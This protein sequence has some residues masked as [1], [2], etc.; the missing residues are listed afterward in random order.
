M[1]GAPGGRFP[2]GLRSPHPCQALCG[3]SCGLTT[4]EP[5]FIQTM[6]RDG[7]PVQ[8][9][10]KTASEPRSTSRDWGSVVI[11]GPT[12]VGGGRSRGCGGQGAGPFYLPL[13]SPTMLAPS[14]TGQASSCLGLAWELSRRT[15]LPQP[16]LPGAHCGSRQLQAQKKLLWPHFCLDL[17][18]PS[19]TPMLS[20]PL[21]FLLIPGS[22]TLAPGCGG[23]GL[24]PTPESLSAFKSTVHLLQASAGDLEP[25]SPCT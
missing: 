14:P 24:P 8:A 23:R 3:P 6:V 5:R 12:A 15:P 18:P 11:L 1:R 10:L 25:S 4:P 2:P 22:P 7:L 20:H 13:L 16:S 17:Q 19:P 21:P 9:Q